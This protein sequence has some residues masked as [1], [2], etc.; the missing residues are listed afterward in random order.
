M[1][2]AL[3]KF[4]FVFRL[5]W[6]ERMV[7]RVNFF[8]EIISGILSSLIVIFLWI[9]IYRGAGKEVIGGYSLGEMVTYV[10]GGGLINSFILTTAENPETSQNIQDGTLS[11]YLIQPINPYGIWFFRD[12]GSKTFFFVLGLSGYLV[13]CLFFGKY[14]VF[15]ASLDHL[16]YFLISLILASFLQFFLFQ[17][18]SLL[19]FWVENTYGIR[20]TMRVIRLQGLRRK[21]YSKAKTEK[22][23][24]FWG[25]YC[26]ILKKEVLE[27]AYRLAKANGGAPGIDGKSF[28]DIEAE[29]VEGFLEGIRQ[30]LLSRTLPTDDQQAGGNT[31]REG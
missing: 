1:Y 3:V 13:V 8:M 6:I 7:Y 14:I 10:L 27:E 17:S 5:A 31:Q 2:H 19:S 22:C 16:I 26:H 12:L 9:A 21:I 24:R 15:S 25:L 23:W 11:T 28:E 18:F 20:F 4:C 30:E 29:G